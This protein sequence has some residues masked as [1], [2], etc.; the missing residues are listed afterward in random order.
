MEQENLYMQEIMIDKGHRWSNQQIKDLHLDKG[1]LIVLVERGS[2]TII[3]DGKTII[4]ENDMLV[5]VRSE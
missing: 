2:D 5:V 4:K 1:I 3:P